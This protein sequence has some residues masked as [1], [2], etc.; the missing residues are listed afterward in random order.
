[1]SNV[2]KVLELL[3]ASDKSWEDAA[4][5]AVKKASETLHNVKSI[6][7]ENFEAKVDDEKIVEYRI[8]AK[9][10]FLLD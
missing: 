9:V 8:N 7:I 2:L 10:T 4:A 6:Y 1:M 5:Q 3:A